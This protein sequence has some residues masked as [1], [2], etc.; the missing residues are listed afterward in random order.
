MS[1]TEDMAESRL[2]ES[3]LGFGMALSGS[4][5]SSVCIQQ[6]TDSDMCSEHHAAHGLWTCG[7]W[8]LLRS[9]S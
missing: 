3:F 4:C 7:A 2:P 5:L 9:L 6:G 8:S 1:D